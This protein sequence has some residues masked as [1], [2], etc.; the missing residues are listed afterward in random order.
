MQLRARGGPMGELRGTDYLTFGRA[1]VSFDPR[2]SN[3]PVL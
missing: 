2:R 3:G 1:P